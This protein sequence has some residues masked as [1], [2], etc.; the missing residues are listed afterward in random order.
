MDKVF[1]TMSHSEPDFRIT[2]ADPSAVAR[3]MV[4]SVFYEQVLPA[5]DELSLNITVLAV[6]SVELFDGLDEATKAKLMG[7]TVAAS[8]MGITDFTPATLYRFVTSAAGRA[9]TLHPFRAGHF[10]G[11]GTPERVMKQAGLDA[12]S[13]LEAIRSWAD[14][15]RKAR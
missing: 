8:A 1:L 10:L 4:A 5:L 2:L 11:S 9:A 14:R 15:G 13:Q 12:D 3:R 7:P 6:T